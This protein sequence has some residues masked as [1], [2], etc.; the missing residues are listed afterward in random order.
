MRRVFCRD[1]IGVPRMSN[2]AR[3]VFDS[4][5][6]EGVWRRPVVCGMPRISPVAVP[7]PQVVPLRRD[8][9]QPRG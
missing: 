6:V 5:L 1:R 7:G 3:G 9:R 8:R 2:F 4:V